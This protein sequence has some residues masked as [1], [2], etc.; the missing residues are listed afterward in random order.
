MRSRSWWPA[1]PA[2]YYV[3][4]W[5]YDG[6][7]ALAARL[8]VLYQPRP[9]PDLRLSTKAVDMATALP[10]EVLG[11]TISLINSGELVDIHARVTDA[12]PA[13]TEYI[14]DSLQ[15][16][17]LCTYA[18]GLV[19]CEV[20]MSPT[21]SETIS[22]RVRV[23][24]ALSEETI[25][26]N[27]AIIDDGAGTVLEK[28]ASTT[29]IYPANIWSGPISADTVW[30]AAQS[31][32][33][34]AGDLTIEEGVTLTIEPGVEVR[35]FPWDALASGVDPEKV[36]LI[37]EGT[38]V[39]DGEPEGLITFTS[40]TS[41]PAGGDWYGIRFS[42]S[43]TDWGSSGCILDHTVIRYASVGISIDA[44]SPMISHNAIYEIKGDD[45]LGGEF[46]SAGEDAYGI[47]CLK[48]T[49]LRPLPAIPSLV[50]MAAMAAVVGVTLTART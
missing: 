44:A 50:S 40:A 36:E 16:F 10:G 35:F 42:D 15:P 21:G 1:P 9:K 8:H 25:I 23:S 27:T 39:A 17:W 2:T 3:N 46:I 29:I 43:S 19:T 37:V 48:T 6:N 28:S 38:L 13:H 31:P 11:Y 30:R 32:Y 24:P 14:P 7:P 45:G 20:W 12:I 4:V 22:F 41:R 34:V 33:Y 49:R 47:R 26:T 5:A 18:D